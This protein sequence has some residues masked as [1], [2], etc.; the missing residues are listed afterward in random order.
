MVNNI[1]IECGYSKELSGLLTS[2][3]TLKGRL[4]QGAP[5]SPAL[6]NIVLIDF[7]R[8]ISNYAQERSMR[9]TRYADDM[10]F[11]GN[12]NDEDVI[13]LINLVRKEL[14][15]IGMFLNKEKTR[16]LTPNMRQIVTGVVV[17]EKMQTSRNYRKNIRQSVY[18]INKF[19]IESHMQKKGL[20]ISDIEILKY[21]RIIEGKI[22]FS[23]MVNPKDREMQK[24]LNEI[25]KLIKSFSSLII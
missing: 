7:D 1:F 16:I 15:K 23:L 9:Y 22:R 18:Y 19:G 13:K 12:L 6:S 21:Y 10:T 25:T 24:Y 20:Y 2:L 4:T 5:T 3:L 11:S 14:L 8:T 17:N